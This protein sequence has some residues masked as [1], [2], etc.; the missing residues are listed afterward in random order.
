VGTLWTCRPGPRGSK[1][2]FPI[3]GTG[4]RFPS[5]EGEPGNQSGNAP[6]VPGTSGN[7]WE[8][9]TSEAGHI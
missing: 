4:S 1:N 6:L 8:P 5:K 2:F 9:G 7:Q 3:E